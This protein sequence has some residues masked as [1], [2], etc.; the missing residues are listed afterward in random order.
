M[1]K[2]KLLVGTLAATVLTVGAGTAVAAAQQSQGTVAAPEANSEQDPATEANQLQGLAKIDQATAEKA[3]LNAVPGQVQKT[4]LG[5]ENG[6]VV[7]DVEVLGND[8]KTTDVQVDAGNGQVLGQ[9]NEN[10][11]G[12]GGSDANESGG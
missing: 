8:G 5:D 11:D 2:K 10:D 7:Y 9:E 12:P 3:A 1:D 4:E 6:F